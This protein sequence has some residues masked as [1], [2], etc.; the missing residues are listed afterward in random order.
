[1]STVHS[2]AQALQLA[3]ELACEFATRAAAADVHATLPAEDVAA[4]RSAGFFAL[5][6]PR[7]HGGSGL[8][9][10][11]CLAIQIEL[12]RGSAATAMVLGMPLHIFGSANEHCPWLPNA[13]AHLCQLAAAGAL[14]NA[15]ASEPEMGSPSRGGLP[16]STL[17]AHNA[18]GYV[19]N[20]LKTWTTGGRHLTHML[21][22]VRLADKAAI[23]LVETGRAGVEWD[24][25]WANA[26]SLRASDSHD[27]RFNNVH[28]PAE[29]LI[30]P[31]CV[32]PG[33]P[34]NAWFPVM[35]AAV[36]LGSAIAARNAVIQFALE[37][38]PT[39]LGAPIATLPK[40]QRQI[41]ALDVRLMSARTLLEAAVQDWDGSAAAQRALYPRIVAAKY[42]VSEA[43]NE[44]TDAA[45]RIAGGTSITRT[46]PLERHFRDV[47]A[48]LMQPPSGDTAL[49]LIGRS[50]L[51]EGGATAN[52]PRAG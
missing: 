18:G 41:G 37:R 29:N 7:A 50:A 23:V 17:N 38:T 42:V 22:R 6:V 16:Q 2:A 49:E 4:L 34:P 13:F 24:E 46:L 44:V 26:L 51:A 20:G 8:T 11:E 48:G 25:T 52:P 30:Q 19:L 14:V 10:A 45:L 27:V 21:V 12:A 33:A 1:M 39:A 36:Y 43:A 9:L 47:R 5:S 15:V 35:M 31:G 40:I 3:R 32:V 28:L